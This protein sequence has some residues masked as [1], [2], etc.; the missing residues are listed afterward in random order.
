MS[1]SGL[2]TRFQGKVEHRFDMN[3]NVFLKNTIYILLELSI[4]CRAG[5]GKII[6]CFVPKFIIVALMG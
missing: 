5:G 3:R 1:N 6:P 2:N 4:D